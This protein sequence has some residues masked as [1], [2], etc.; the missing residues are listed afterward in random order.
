MAPSARAP[1][2]PAHAHVSALDGIKSAENRGEFWFAVADKADKVVFRLVEEFGQFFV[3][4]FPRL[5]GGLWSAQQHQ[6]GWTAPGFDE[7]G[8]LNFAVLG[9]W[10]LI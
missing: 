3:P 4:P 9:P 7:S 6:R 8:K 1:W 5:S 10:P 2:R